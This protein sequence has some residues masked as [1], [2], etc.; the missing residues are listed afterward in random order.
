MRDD[1]DHLVRLLMYS[2][3]LLLL[4]A[5]CTIH[6]LPRQIAVVAVSWTILSLSVA[7][8]FGHCVLNED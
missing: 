3:G 4:M 6:F 1:D 5:A 7:V 8:S 2:I